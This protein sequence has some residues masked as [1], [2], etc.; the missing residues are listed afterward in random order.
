VATTTI[1]VA[2]FESACAECADAIAAESRATAYKWYARAEAIHAALPRTIG[3]QGAELERR[4][5]LDGL[6]RALDA[7]FK[8][9]AQTGSAKR[10][11]S[12]R[13][14]YMGRQG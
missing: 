5:A 2:S 9:I 4:T 10:F 7:A 11:I 1:T 3:D 8:V 14:G 6:K 12:T 13:T